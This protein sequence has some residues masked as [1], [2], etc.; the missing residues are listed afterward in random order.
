LTPLIRTADLRKTYLKGTVSIPVLR[1]VSLEIA[2]GEYVSVAGRSGSGKSTLLNL[3]GGLD[4]ATGGKILVGDYDVTAM[5]RQSLAVHRRHTVGMIFQSFNL[6]PSRTA[7]ENI[8]LALAF[9][10]H[11]RRD[12]RRR[13]SELLESVG[14]GHRTDHRPGELSGGEAQRVAIARALAND[15]EVLLADEPTGN[16]DSAT[17]GEIIGLLRDLN[18]EN[19]LTVVM[20]SHDEAAA[21]EVSHRVFRLLDGT[22]VDEMVP[23]SAT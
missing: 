9:G 21:R 16:L 14:L 2:R 13:A 17:A 6:I 15:P 1:G 8:T 3:L 23:G 7:L 12:R 4:T 10:G 19:G 5:N 20:V 18:R 11:P 22:V